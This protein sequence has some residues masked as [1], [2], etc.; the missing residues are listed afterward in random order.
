MLH[1]YTKVWIHLIIATKDQRPFI[2]KRIEREVYDCLEEELAAL[3]CQLEVINGMPDHVH[4]LFVQSPNYS[5]Y[6]TVNHL[7]RTTAFR[8]N[9]Q[10][11]FEEEFS[12]QSGCAAFSVSD[13]EVEKVAQFIKDQKTS[14]QQ[15]DFL[16]ESRELLRMH[17]V[18]NPHSFRQNFTEE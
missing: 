8:I 4:L 2:G 12:W 11:Y 9:E 13:S 14:H 3:G 15:Q 1:I 17:Q 5:I 16:E 10:A 7:K 18:K 6:Q